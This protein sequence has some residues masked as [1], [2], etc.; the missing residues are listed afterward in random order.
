MPNT[1]TRRAQSLGLG[2]GVCDFGEDPSLGAREVCP[3][4]ETGTDH[5]LRVRLARTHDA[6]R[7]FDLWRV[8]GRKRLTLVDDD[9][10]LTVEQH[11]RHLQISL[12]AGLVDGAGYFCTVPLTAG[13]PSR[14]DELHGQL[15]ILDGRT[16]HSSPTQ[17]V[18]RSALLHLRA[19]QAFDAAQAGASQRSIA[20][21]LFGPEVV[22]RRWQ[23]DS[24]LRAQVRH[25]LRRATAY[26]AGD[27]LILA[28]V[29][30]PA[31]KAPGDEPLR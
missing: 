22:S 7:R 6:A 25:L 30:R 12:D 13:L 17:P 5:L 19:L 27:Y 16:P 18:S 20:I 2:A 29:R 14:L 31:A 24:E 11:R 1:P 9:L 8:S 3:Q 23:A 10:A 15:K 4:W 26:V 21:A 28:G